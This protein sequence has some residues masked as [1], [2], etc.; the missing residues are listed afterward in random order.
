MQ[1]GAVIAKLVL[2][3]VDFYAFQPNYHLPLSQIIPALARTAGGA[4]APF[5]EKC[6]GFLPIHTIPVFFQYIRQRAYICCPG[7]HIINMWHSM[8]LGGTSDSQIIQA[9]I[10][11]AVVLLAPCQEIWYWGY[12]PSIQTITVG[13]KIS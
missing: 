13:L 6:L 5:L 7:R 2:T 3:Y 12:Y 9:V 8:P 1:F 10:L 4:L 11:P